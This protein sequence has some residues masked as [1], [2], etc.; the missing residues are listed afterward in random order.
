MDHCEC[1]G[2][3]LDVEQARCGHWFCYICRGR[4][5]DEECDGQA[6]HSR[7]IPAEVPA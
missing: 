5:H 3:G 6:G 1:C 4:G 7:P 2:L